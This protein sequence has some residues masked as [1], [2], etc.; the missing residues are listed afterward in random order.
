MGPDY[1]NTTDAGYIDDEG[2]VF[3]MSRTDDIINAV[4]HRFLAGAMEEV[5]ANH[6]HAAECPVIGIY[7]ALEG[8]VPIGF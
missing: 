7:D 6:A 3:V 4:G 8:Q 1:Y 5:L 2:Y